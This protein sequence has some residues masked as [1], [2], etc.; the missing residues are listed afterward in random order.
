MTTSLKL[1][2]LCSLERIPY[3]SSD[4]IPRNSNFKPAQPRALQ[5]LELALNI[6]DIG[7]NVYLAGEANLGRKFFVEE[8]LKPY[9]KKMPTP[10]DLV[11][12]NNFEDQDKPIL[13]TLPSGVGRI[14][15]NELSK[16][17]QAI[18]KE[19]QTRF[20]SD[21][22]IKKRSNLLDEFND[23]KTS[24][25]KEMNKIAEE[26]GFAL[27]F[28]DKTS[29]TL[30]PILDGKKV[31]EQEFETLPDDVKLDFKKRSDSILHVMSSI[32]RKITK[33]E[34]DTREFERNLDK[35]IMNEVLIR[36]FTPFA[37][38]IIKSLTKHEFDDK[39]VEQYLACVRNDM[40]E[41]FE[42]FLPKEMPQQAPADHW[43]PLPQEPEI[44]RYE[45]NVFVDN[46]ET[47]GAPIFCEPNPTAH[48]LLGCI[49]RESE[50]GV[51]ITDFTLIKA[52]ALH[53]ALGGF[54][55]VHI[56]DLLQHTNAWEG[57][58]RALRAGVSRIHEAS[59]QVEASKIKGIDPQAIPLDVKIILIGGDALYENLLLHDER[60]NKFFK[61][62]AQLSD[63]S[64]R[65]SANIK[66]WVQHLV[67]IIDNANLLPFNKEALAELVDYSSF[68]CD[69]QRK[70]SLQF[71]IIREVMI[72]S[73]TLATIENKSIVDKD[74]VHR[75]LQ[76]R[77]QRQ[78]YLK[79][80]V[81]EDYS[82]QLIKIQTKGFEVGK[83]NAL[84]L[85]TYGEYEFGLPHKIA[86]TVGVGHG[87][88]IDLEREAE[89]SGP[90]H[91]KAMMIL[92]GYLLSLFARTKPLVFTGSLC[93]E[94]SYGG[95]E[96]DS[97]SGA[98]LAA[99]LSALADVP[100]NLSLA[101][102]GA[103]SHAGDILSVGGVTK[104]IEGYFDICNHQ[105]LTGEQG[106]I[107]PYDNRDNLMLN[108]SVEEA[109][110]S[111][112]FHIYPVKHITEA[113]NLL[114]GMS[115]GKMRKDSTFTPNSL[116]D[117]VD[118]KLKLFGWYAE[119]S[120]KKKPKML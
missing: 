21:N 98:E 41:N 63:S 117:K 42:I 59:E 64:Q 48:N 115:C 57:L 118:N 8:Y 78:S 112:K 81:F 23:E 110:N 97:A 38:K 92:K 61:I 84:S 66:S 7:Y 52:G 14:F 1:N 58:L 83:V 65:N 34:N 90:I 73:S 6:N 39:E 75:T 28:E 87:G 91:T 50:M 33:A 79:D 77:E 25:L 105:G 101:F 32:I 116:Y 89:L 103:V 36:L 5:A 35:S 43:I 3:D 72:E 67:P 95:V 37:N 56:D 15:K 47:K 69:D 12:V 22:Y 70:L 10:P 27:D 60:F 53:K 74:C 30:F 86:C 108:K 85:T 9:A 71:P 68:L 45:V 13:L 29:L 100:I 62:K 49:E 106:V 80:L 19:L 16:T 51:L 54:L 104:K 11:Y 94:Q 40:L 46:S 55:I 88:V 4:D 96:G 99:L 82:R 111:G 76:S 17:V 113:L 114:T 44:F 20:E 109:V 102:T 119:N 2:A 31:S 120:Y 24:S 107:L 26:H 93:F 18:R